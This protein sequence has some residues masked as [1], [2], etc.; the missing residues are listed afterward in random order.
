MLNLHMNDIIHT[1]N[2]QASELDYFKND[3]KIF[4]AFKSLSEEDRYLI[5]GYINGSEKRTDQIEK[6]VNILTNLEVSLNGKTLKEA[7][8]AVMV[9]RK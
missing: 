4:T 2:D 7:Y 5:I 8:R 6:A 3:A 1:L 9:A